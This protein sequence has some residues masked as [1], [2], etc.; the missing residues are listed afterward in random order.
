MTDTSGSYLDSLVDIMTLQ[1]DGNVGIGT[2]E[3]TE[4]LDVN[5]DKIRIRTAN[6]PASASA[7]GAVGEICWDADYIYVCTATD[8]WK[9][10]AI[11]TW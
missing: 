4:A 6:T 2:T 11:S 10:T 7:T 3:P 1:A 9:R 8:T 5:S